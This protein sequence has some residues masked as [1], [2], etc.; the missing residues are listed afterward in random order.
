MSDRHMTIGIVLAVACVI[1]GS[2]VQARQLQRLEAVVAQHYPQELVEES[3]DVR[4][5][6]PPRNQCFAVLEASASGAPQIV[7][8]GYTNLMSGAIRLLRGVSNGFEVAAGSR[9][10]DLSGQEC[11]VEAVDLD[12]DGRKEAVVHF[13]TRNSS[14]D[15][16][17]RG[18]GEDL[19][20]LSPTTSDALGLV[21][22]NLVNTSFVDVDGDHV[23]EAFIFSEPRRE[24]QPSPGAIYRFSGNSYVLDRPIVGM[25]TFER[26][27]GAPQTDIQTI[28]LPAGAAGPFT[29]RVVNGAGV[30]GGKGNKVEN[31]VESGRVWWNGQEI[32]SP[33]HFGNHVALIERTVTLQSENELKVR[34]AGSPDGRI[35]ILIDAANWTP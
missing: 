25:R 16:V 3:L 20:N 31:A 2:A 7:V 27:S 28:L 22:T 13:L 11:E 14:E 15:W 18:D 24:G 6:E 1:C 19:R 21:G 17:L 29:L 9:T 35:V 12:N 34:L 23:M 32:V 10:E 26:A 5:V 30:A 8:A 4:G 33:N